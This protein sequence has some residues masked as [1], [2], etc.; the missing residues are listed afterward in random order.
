MPRLGPSFSTLMLPAPFHPSRRVD[1]DSLWSV[2]PSAI[3]TVRHHRVHRLHRSQIFAT[4][5]CIW[6]PHSGRGRYL[7]RF[8]EGS[9]QVLVADIRA[10]QRDNVPDRC[11]PCSVRDPHFKSYQKMT[12]S[13]S[14]QK[15]WLRIH[16]IW[17]KFSDA[18]FLSESWSQLCIWRFFRSWDLLSSCPF[19]NNLRSPPG[20]ARTH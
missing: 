13:S 1:P 10:D 16:D 14:S 3:W 6:H 19:Y 4:D 2:S 18:N 11:T 15:R 12:V 17:A 7:H 20:T 8:P 5:C 9:S